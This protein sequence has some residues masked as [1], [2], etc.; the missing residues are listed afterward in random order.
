LF[1]ISKTILT[2]QMAV[3]AAEDLIAG[4][5]TGPDLGNTQQ[6]AL[7]LIGVRGLLVAALKLRVGVTGLVSI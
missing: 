3:V 1:K 5:N 6:M 7:R 4:K 2:V